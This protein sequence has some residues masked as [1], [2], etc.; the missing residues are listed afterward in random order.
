MRLGEIDG[1]DGDV[2]ARGVTGIPHT[3]VVRSL[4]SVCLTI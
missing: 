4:S 2:P 3:R 1:T